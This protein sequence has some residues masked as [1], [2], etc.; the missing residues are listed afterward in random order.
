MAFPFFQLAWA[1][2]FSCWDCGGRY[3]GKYALYE[4]FKLDGGRIG[5]AVEITS[6]HGITNNEA[7]RI[8]RRKI[9]YR[10]AGSPTICRPRCQDRRTARR[11]RAPARR[12]QLNGPA[13]R[14]AAI[15]ANQQQPKNKPCQSS[16]MESGSGPHKTMNTN[17]NNPTADGS[18]KTRHDASSDRSAPATAAEESGLRALYQSWQRCGPTDRRLFLEDIRAGS[19]NLWSSVDRDAGSRGR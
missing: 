11:F 5:P 17:T 10:T 15:F 18:G 1:V 3:S 6:L 12:K 8:L 19:R 2:H 13:T 16:P 9:R 7:V 4:L 14:I